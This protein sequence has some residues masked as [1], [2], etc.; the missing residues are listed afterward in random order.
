MELRV[1]WKTD[2]NEKDEEEVEEN[3]W[4]EKNLR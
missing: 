1:T 3:S 2:L 4:I